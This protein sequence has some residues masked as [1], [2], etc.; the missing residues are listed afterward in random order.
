MPDETAKDFIWFVC[1]YHYYRTIITSL[2]NTCDFWPFRR[3]NISIKNIFMLVLVEKSEKAQDFLS[4]PNLRKFSFLDVWENVHLFLFEYRESNQK[5]YDA[6]IADKTDTYRRKKT[7][8]SLINYNRISNRKIMEN[9]SHIKSSSSHIYL[10]IMYVHPRFALKRIILVFHLFPYYVSKYWLH[11]ANLTSFYIA[12]EIRALFVENKFISVYTNFHLP[13][14]W[15]IW[16]YI[17]ILRNTLQK[18]G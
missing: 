3:R 10:L 5:R 9:F 18:K 15:M 7:V 17:M 6:L 16:N 8:S 14:L 2:C 11:Y 4:F 1:S 13:H 12:N